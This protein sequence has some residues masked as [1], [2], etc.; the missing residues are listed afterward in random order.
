MA[1]ISSVAGDCLARSFVLILY[2]RVAFDVYFSHL[3][4][5]DTLSHCMFSELHK[6]VC[7]SSK[8]RETRIFRGIEF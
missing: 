4:T 8:T 1:S 5:Q 6:V 2:F 3:G 7:C